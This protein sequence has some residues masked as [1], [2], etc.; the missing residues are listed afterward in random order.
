MRLLKKKKKKKKNKEG[1]KL[2]RKERVQSILK[3]YLFISV[4]IFSYKE[5]CQAGISG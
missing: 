5:R 1:R 4:K 3:I 2:K